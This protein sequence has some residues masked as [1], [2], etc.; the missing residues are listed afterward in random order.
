MYVFRQ[1]LIVYSPRANLGAGIHS[2]VSPYLHGVLMN[3]AEMRDMVGSIVDYDPNVQT[4][5]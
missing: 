1:V 5:K 4:Y 3:L 2:G